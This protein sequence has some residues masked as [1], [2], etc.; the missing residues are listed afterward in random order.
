MQTEEK[1]SITLELIKYLKQHSISQK[2]FSSRAGIPNA[3]ITSIVNNS[4]TYKT[5]SG[6][7][8]IADHHY[9]SI[10]NFINPEETE[11]KIQTTPQ[12]IMMLSEL[13]EAQKHSYTR[14]LIGETGCGKTFVKNLYKR[15]NPTEVISVVVGS[16]DTIPS[17]LNKV[18]LALRCPREKRTSTQK[19]RDIS[20]A[21]Q[22]IYHH[23]KKPMLIFDEA[24]Y[25]KPRTLCNIKEFYDAL[26]GYCSIILIGTR[27]LTDEIEKL[28]KKDAKGIP[29]FYRR[30]KFA[31]RKLPNI[32]RSF[33]EFLSDIE[34]K[35]LRV[36]LSRNCENYGELHD[37]L[38]PSYREAKRL[39]RTLDL[40]LVKTVIGFKSVLA[41]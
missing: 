30:I 5:A 11:W 10:K 33:T 17:L 15:K 18:C 27:Q 29:Q 20:L 40:D 8:N 19:I 26:Q 3:Y 22:A 41:I 39:Q 13:E 16:E 37:V 32:N 25:M 35:E 21:L 9:S 12:M 31:I 24:E 23:G 1:K 28:R 6:E 36:F 7:Y 4:F 14:V 38:V 2:D 34:D